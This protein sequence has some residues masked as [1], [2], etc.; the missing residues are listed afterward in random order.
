MDVGGSEMSKSNIP[1]DEEFA[2]AKAAMRKQDHGL[3]QVRDRIL[4]RFRERGVHE[5][6]VLFSRPTSTFGAYVFYRCDEE[7]A[8]A[9]DAGLAAEIRD[10]VFEELTAV[11]RGERDTLDVRFEFD[12]HENIERHFEGDYY[13]RLR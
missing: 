5:F 1:S 4:K 13:N 8:K 3:S 7:I 2:R 10:A 11:G 6:F 12:S 9:D